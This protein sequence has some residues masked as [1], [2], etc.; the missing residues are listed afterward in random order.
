MKA[1]V[2]KNSQNQTIE[3][4][5]M[6]IPEISDNAVLVEV[7]AFGV[8][9]HDR[10]FIPNEANFPYTIGSEAAGVI[11]KTGDKIFRFKTGD[12][13]ILT[14]VLQPKGGCWAEY[15]AVPEDLLTALP[16][17][18]DFTEGAAI[19]VAGKKA[20][21]SMRAPDLKKGDTLFVADAPGA[22]GNSNGSAE[23][24]PRYRVRLGEKSRV[25]DVARRG[26]SG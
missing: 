23:R 2:R 24:H 5:E 15:V 26:K 9:I 8:G 25:Y 17:K 22:S 21:E 12:R 7:R 16:D 19:S 4:A 11:T 1:L 13:V 3:M 20:I 18:M 14:S 6:P 10:Y